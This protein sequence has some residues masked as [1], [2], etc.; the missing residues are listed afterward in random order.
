ME[1]AGMDETS[2]QVIRIMEAKINQPPKLLNKYAGNKSYCIFRVPESLVRINKK[3][4]QPRIISICPYHHG[5]DHLKMMQEHK[6][7]FYYKKIT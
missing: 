7:R 3:D 2:H 4:Y 1:A 6:W 5:K